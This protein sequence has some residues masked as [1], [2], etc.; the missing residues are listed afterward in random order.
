MTAHVTRISEVALAPRGDT[1]KSAFVPCHLARS[2]RALPSQALANPN[3]LQSSLSD[4]LLSGLAQATL[5]GGSL[6]PLATLGR[7]HLASPVH[8]QGWRASPARRTRR[9]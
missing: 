6:G 5:P 4:V 2:S 8:L 9:C 3:Q 7:I 1:H